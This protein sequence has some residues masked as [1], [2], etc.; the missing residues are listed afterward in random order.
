AVSGAW[1]KSPWTKLSSGPSE[2]TGKRSLSSRRHLLD[3][4]QHQLTI[5]IV[6][7]GRI[8]PY[9]AQETHLVFAQWRKVLRVAIAVI[10]VE[11]LAQRNIH[12]AGNFGKRVQ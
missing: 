7:I 11:E 5:T 4:R 10:V 6:Q 8:A 9:L 1:E 2:A 12:G 3:H